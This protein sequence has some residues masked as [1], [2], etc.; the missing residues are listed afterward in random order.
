MIKPDIQ[1]TGRFLITPTELHGLFLIK[2]KPVI[3]HRGEFC[4][5][6]CKDE[7]LSVGLERPI[8]QINMSKTLRPGSIRGMHFQTGSN[9]EEK[10]VTCTAGRI[11][12]VAVD[13]RPNSETY[14]SWYATELSSDNH[15]SLV[16]P[17]GFAHGFQ[18]LVEDCE[19]IYFVTSPYSQL[20]ENG[21]HPMDPSI[22][23]NWP[24]LC[25]E[26]SDK[27][28]SRQFIAR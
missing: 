28:A 5:L 14:L 10:I 12:D 15:T 18:S 24:L 4:R 21:L 22:G 3:D 9:A 13:M 25:T 11:F 7:L 17:T 16:I 8:V 6:Y 27:D 19:I 20:S 23:I 2:Q 1:D 26:M